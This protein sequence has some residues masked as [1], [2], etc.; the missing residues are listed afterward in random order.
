MQTPDQALNDRQNHDSRPQQKRR[1]QCEQMGII[2]ISQELK[3]KLLVEYSQA[4][5]SKMAPLAWL[6][7]V[8][9]EKNMDWISQQSHSKKIRI[10]SK[11]LRSRWVME[12]ILKRSPIFKGILAMSIPEAVW[13]FEKGLND[14]LVAYPTAQSADFRGLAQAVKNGAQITLMADRPEHLDLIQYYANSESLNLRVAIDLDVSSDF[15]PLHFG[16]YRSSIKTV[17]DL[18][19]LLALRKQWPRVEW[20]GLMAYEAQLAGV[21]DFYSNTLTNTLKGWAVQHLKRRSKSQVLERRQEAVACLRNHDVEL[22]FV[23]GG[24][25]GS[26]AWTSQDPSITEVTVGSGF[27]APVL[28]DSFRD[29]TLQPSLG[30]ALRVSRR[31]QNG[32]IT[33][34]GGGYPASGSAGSDRLPTPY[35]PSNLELLS[36]EGAGEVQTPVRYQTPNESQIHLGDLIFFRHPKA[37]ELCE[38][39][40]SLQ[41]IRDGQWIQETPTYRG[42]GQQWM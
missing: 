21:P 16:V 41:L 36:L 14:F 1:V 25:T 12:T 32:V 9:F 33:C 26:L 7:L 30:F 4:L 8:A 2:Q 27:Y 5:K 17:D 11:S 22:E 35:L 37:G 6:D 24:G 31:P 13:L 42:E 28:F 15:G 19:A 38:R 39:F 34:N 20:V 23:N 40:S 3:S 10:G 18:S 29:L